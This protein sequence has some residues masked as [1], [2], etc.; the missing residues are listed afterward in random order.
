MR[1]PPRMETLRSSRIVPIP[2]MTLRVARSR[3]PNAKATSR[4]SS[5]VAMSGA[6]AISTRGMPNRSSRYTTSFSASPSLRA[7]SSSRRIVGTPIRF[8]LTSRRPSSA[9]SPDR[10]NPD[11]FDPSITILRMK[12]TSWT[13]FASSRRAISSVM[14]SASGFGGGGGFCQLGPQD[15]IPPARAVLTKG[16]GI[17][18]LRFAVRGEEVFHVEVAVELRHRRHPEQEPLRVIGLQGRCRAERHEDGVFA[19]AI[20]VSGRHV[21][22]PV[23]LAVRLQEHVPDAFVLI[24]GGH[25][26]RLCLR[27]GGRCTFGIVARSRLRPMGSWPLSIQA[28]SMGRVFDFA[29]RRIAGYI[30]FW[31]L[32]FLFLGLFYGNDRPAQAG[33]L[34]ILGFAFIG[35]LLYTR[36][37]KRKQRARREAREAAQR[38]HQAQTIQPPPR[39]PP[40]PQSPPTKQTPGR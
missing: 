37:L 39:M 6:V 1:A 32:V 16:L 33:A 29:K 8:P 28:R 25:E 27:D 15:V 23:R 21:V 5:G 26:D 30:V 14:S 24:E 38:M 34:F 19:A 7:A 36:R 4:A 10:W 18:R 35:S 12:S 2:L 17:R 20:E 13:G 40:P 11:V 22:L 3:D 9:T 31:V